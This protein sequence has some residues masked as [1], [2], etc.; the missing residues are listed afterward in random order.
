[1]APYEKMRF[2]DTMTLKESLLHCMQPEEIEDNTYFRHLVI[3]VCSPY[4][5][6]HDNSSYTFLMQRKFARSTDKV[7]TN[8]YTKFREWLDANFPV[9]TEE[10]WDELKEEDL[11]FQYEGVSGEPLTEEIVDLDDTYDV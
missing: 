4:A 7:P 2:F 6:A 3:L 10:Q 9:I 11:R 1:M 5:G 8:F